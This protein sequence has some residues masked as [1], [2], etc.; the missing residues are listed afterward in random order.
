[1]NEA[2]TEATAV[3][4]RVLRPLSEPEPDIFIVDRPFLFYIYDRINHL[5]LFVGRVID[6]RGKAKLKPLSPFVKKD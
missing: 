3:S 1:M 2:G 5:Q 4:T 6:P